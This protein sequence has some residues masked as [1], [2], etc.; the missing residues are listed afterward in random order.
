MR[1]DGE[2]PTSSVGTGRPKTGLLR[3]V[4][5]AGIQPIWLAMANQCQSIRQFVR[6]QSAV[7]RTIRPEYRSSKAATGS[8]GC[9]AAPA[10][11]IDIVSLAARAS[12]NH[13]C[14]PPC[15]GLPTNRH[16]LEPLLASLR[17]AHCC[18]QTQVAAR[19]RLAC[20][21]ARAHRC[22]SIQPYDNETRLQFLLTSLFRFQ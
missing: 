1:S 15:G 14:T 13:A 6:R 5:R 17:R 9:P 12:P 8:A 4:A 18:R 10:R 21:R 7:Y 22:T 3:R 19:I 11:L 16:D 20:T 2:P